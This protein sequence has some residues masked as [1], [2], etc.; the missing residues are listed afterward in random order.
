MSRTSTFLA[1]LLP[2]SLLLG[3]IIAV[4]LLVMGEQGLPR[5][6]ALRDEL[7]EVQRTNERMREEVRQLQ[8]DVRSLR[9]DERAIERIARDE[10]GMVREGEIV[11]QFPE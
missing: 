6:R 11:F 8:H 5:Y 9:A 3:S 7:A 10:L 2:L 1:W 4:P